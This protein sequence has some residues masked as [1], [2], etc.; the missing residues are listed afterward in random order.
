M[1]FF[2]LYKKIYFFI[3]YIFYKNDFMLILWYGFRHW[4]MWNV[5]VCVRERVS[6]DVWVICNWM[7][8]KILIRTIVRASWHTKNIY[9]SMNLVMFFQNFNSSFIKV[10]KNSLNLSQRNSL[11]ILSLW[12]LPKCSHLEGAVIF[13]WPNCLFFDQIKHW[14]YFWKINCVGDTRWS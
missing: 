4:L 2:S 13:V 9:F 14:R 8:S 10:K 7:H 5:C 6:G 12:V 3:I 1:F 11:C